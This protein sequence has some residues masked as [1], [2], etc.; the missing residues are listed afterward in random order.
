[1]YDSNW[2]KTNIEELTKRSTPVSNFCSGNLILLRGNQIDLI[3]GEGGVK[4]TTIKKNIVNYK[5]LQ[6]CNSVE[7][8]LKL[9]LDSVRDLTIDFQLDR[10]IVDAVIY[11]VQEEEVEAW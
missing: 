1:M 11:G 10:K 2:L 9:L 6:K 4:F 8:R 7:E 3:K 5:R